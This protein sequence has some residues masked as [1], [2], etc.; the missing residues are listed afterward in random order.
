MSISPYQY[1]MLT[2]SVAIIR[3][4]FH[5]FCISWLNH[6]NRYQMN[7]EVF[8]HEQVILNNEHQLFN[9]LQQCVNLT[10]DSQKL[11]QFLRPLG[12]QLKT[13]H[14]TERDIS[15]LCNSLLVTL[16][17]HLSRQFTLAMRNAWRR[18][19]HLV[20]NVLNHEMFGRHNIVSL[21]EYKARK[22]QAC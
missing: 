2:Q 15:V 4:N 17:L 5:C 12:E 13:F 16:Q 3:P 19:L 8:S 9:F 22:S 1:R 6:V 11:I 21:S 14:M 10:V 18:L 7:S 20:A